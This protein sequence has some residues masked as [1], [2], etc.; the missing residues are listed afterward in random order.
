MKLTLELKESS[1]YKGGVYVEIPFDVKKEY[2]K[3]RVRI[4]ASFDG[5]LYRGLLS[6]MDGIY[7]IVV[8]KAIRAKINKVVGETVVVE[9]EEDKEERSIDYPEMLLDKLKSVDGLEDFYKSLSFTTRK[10]IAQAIV[11]AV[12][13]ETK[14]RR[15]EKYFKELQDL[16]NKRKKT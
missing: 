13:P 14:A 8:T 1:K 11:Q 12:R 7:I 5:E 16:Y 4:K 10:E 6:K 9:I 2:G 3:G 15:L